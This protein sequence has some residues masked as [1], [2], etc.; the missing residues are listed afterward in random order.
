[1]ILFVPRFKPRSDLFDVKAEAT[2]PLRLGGG[3][4][5]HH[6]RAIPDACS[7][8]AQA[9]LSTGKSN[10]YEGGRARR[11]SSWRFRA[12]WRAEEIRHPTIGWS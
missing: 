4:R 7:L 9:P 10:A 2:S 6:G 12:A 1:M 8:G 3:G 11:S 5:D